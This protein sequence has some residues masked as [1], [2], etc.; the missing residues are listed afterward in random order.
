MGPPVT[1]GAAGAVVSVTVTVKDPEA[2]LPT[3]SVA[4][5]VTGAEVPSAKVEPDA[6]LQLKLA[7]PEV[8][9]APMPL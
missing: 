2:V 9:E 5:Q 1:V 8:S 3:V 6:G 4:L 7:M